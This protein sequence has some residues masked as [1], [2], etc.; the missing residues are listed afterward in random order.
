MLAIK[1]DVT[2][3]LDRLGV[4]TASF[5]EMLSGGGAVGR[6]LEFLTQELMREASTLTA[7]L[8]SA[9]LKNEGLDL[10]EL[11]DGLREQVLNLA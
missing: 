7:K 8:H 11:V 1:A 9:E 10:K 4:H 6:R 3:E 2:E 5:S